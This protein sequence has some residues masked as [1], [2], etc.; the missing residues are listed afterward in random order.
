MCAFWSTLLTLQIWVSGVTSLSPT[1]TDCHLFAF[2]S[3]L[4]K[5]CLGVLPFPVSPW[6]PNSLDSFLTWELSL[7]AIITHTGDREQRTQD[8]TQSTAHGHLR[9]APQVTNRGR[10]ARQ[11]CCC[12]TSPEITGSCT[13][14]CKSKSDPPAPGA[15]CCGGSKIHWRISHTTL[16][17][18]VSLRLLQASPRSC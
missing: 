10:F 7:P 14:R 2:L 9:L 17:G 4:P 1:H 6:C 8:I 5:D 18:A 11:H 16:P 15:S 12:N 3:V 13:A